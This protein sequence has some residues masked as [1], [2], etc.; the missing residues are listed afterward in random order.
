MQLVGTSDVVRL[1]MSLK[2]SGWAGRRHGRDK[3]RVRKKERKRNER[4]KRIRGG[5]KRKE[6]KRKRKAKSSGQGGV[7]MERGVKRC[8]KQNRE[9]PKGLGP[10]SY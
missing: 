6:E 5:E 1:K 9:N 3:T 7:W 2:W 10:A 8:E 4:E